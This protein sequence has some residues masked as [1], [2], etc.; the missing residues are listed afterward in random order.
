MEGH[1]LTIENRS[2]ISINKVMDVDAFD[3]NN[4]WANIE[5]GTIE[6]YGERLNVEKLDLVEGQL[7]ITGK[8]DGFNY[9]DKQSKEKKSFAKVFRKKL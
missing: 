7:I 8:I 4:L 9:S 5:D 3:E 2:K 6:I 1:I